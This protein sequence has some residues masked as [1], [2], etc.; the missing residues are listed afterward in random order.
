MASSSDFSGGAVDMSRI[1]G[2]DGVYLEDIGVAITSSAP[3]QLTRLT[4]AGAAGDLLTVER[5]H[6]VYALHI[7]RSEDVPMIAPASTPGV[8]GVQAIGALVC[9]MVS[10]SVLDERRQLDERERTWGLVSTGVIDSTRTGR[11]IRVA[12]LDTG[13]DL[14]HPDFSGR[15]MVSQSFVQGEAVQ[16]GQ[17]HGT[18]CIGT[19]LGPLKPGSAPRYGVAADADVYVGKVLSDTGRGTDGSVLTAIN[20]AVTNRCRIVS[21]SLGSAGQAGV[22][23]SQ[24][25]ETAAQRALAAN[26]LLIA[27]AGNE[28]RR[29]QGQ[30][31]PVGRPADCPSVMAIGAVDAEMRVAPFSTRGTNGLGGGIDLVGPGVDVYSTVPSPDLYGV[32]SGT[33]MACPHVA[34]IAALVAEANPQASARDIWAWLVKNAKRLSLDP[35]DMGAGLVQAPR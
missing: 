8:L 23:Y 14:Q 17:S 7:P 12:V 33:S 9:R 18:H 25:Y 19:A 20:W 11:G 29:A 32:K 13:I 35:A 30:I 4:Q 21:M 28:S 10:P 22:P 1:G 34:G 27:A 31:N 5:E 2:A 24:V 6:V 15:R 26:T 3:E 16:D